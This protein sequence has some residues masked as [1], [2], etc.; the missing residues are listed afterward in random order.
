MVATMFPIPGAPGPPR[1]WPT[2]RAATPLRWSTRGAWPWRPCVRWTSDTAGRWRNT[3]DGH[4]TWES[5]MVDLGN[6]FSDRTYIWGRFGWHDDI[7]L[8]YTDIHVP[9]NPLV[10]P[11]SNKTSKQ[12]DIQYLSPE[13]QWKHWLYTVILTLSFHD[14]GFWLKV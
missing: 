9:C 13:N 11:H 10:R 1:W 2:P 3:G 6:F 7:S 8:L 5:Y 14:L 12:H 4:E